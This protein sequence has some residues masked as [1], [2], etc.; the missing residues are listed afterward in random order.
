[1]SDC[2]LAVALLRLPKGDTN[3]PLSSFPPSLAFLYLSVLPSLHCQSS[4]FLFWTFTKDFSY[5]LKPCLA[6]LSSPLSS[7]ISEVVPLHHAFP[8]S[9]PEARFFAFLVHLAP[10]HPGEGHESLAGFPFTLPRVFSL[11][12]SRD[13][14][15]FSVPTGYSP[16]T[17]WQEQ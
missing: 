15:T 4:L 11:R 8:S 17:L 10:G 6:S 3:W 9:F 7:I 2:L 13:G 5:K 16:P 14:A 1:V 12:H